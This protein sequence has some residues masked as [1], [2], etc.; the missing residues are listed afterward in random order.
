MK[1]LMMDLY[2][3][4]LDM[5]QKYKADSRLLNYVRIWNGESL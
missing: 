3:M 5:K 4:N 2:Y 1:Y